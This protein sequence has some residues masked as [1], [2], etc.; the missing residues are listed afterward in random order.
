VKRTITLLLNLSDEDK[1]KLLETMEAYTVAYH[2]SASWGFENKTWNKISNHRG[3]YSLIRDVVP[4]LPSGLVQAARDVACENL[5][6]LKNRMVPNRKKYS[7]MRFNK[8]VIR[9][10]LNHDFVSISTVR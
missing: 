5:K 1:S 3:T 2:I 9:F 8:N 10:C 6:R 7:A 4:N